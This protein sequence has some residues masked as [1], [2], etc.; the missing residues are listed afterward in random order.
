[1]KYLLG[2]NGLRLLESLC[3]TK[4]LFA[5]D[6]DGTLAPIVSEPQAARMRDQT[7]A[8]ISELNRIAPVAIVSGRSLNDLRARIGFTP[9]YLV[10]NHGLEGLTL[11]NSTE[12]GSEEISKNWEQN[13]RKLEKTQGVFI[14]NKTYTLAVHYRNCRSKRQAKHDIIE[15]AQALAPAPRVI[16][17]K[18]VVN[19]VPA[20]APHKGIALTQLML[21]SKTR[22][23]F[24]VG[25]DDT[26]EDVFCL[27]QSNRI[28]TVRVGKKKTSQARY[29]LYRQ[30]EINAVLKR[31]ISFLSVN[32]S[33]SEAL[34]AKERHIRGE[35]R[36]QFA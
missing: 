34:E 20:G 18:S 27:P 1:M 28:V 24:Y 29:F 3:F 11:S 30:S 6:F 13:L 19:L 8:L 9:R 36:E 7:M 22:S 10:G 26:D 4:T 33:T 2:Q 15:M 14:E 5:F 32:R 16:F 17:G 25:D 31:L 12:L 23:A 35:S 21:K